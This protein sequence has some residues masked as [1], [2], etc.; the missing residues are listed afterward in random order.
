MMERSWAALLALGLVAGCGQGVSLRV[1]GP[2]GATPVVYLGQTYAVRS[3]ED[4]PQPDLDPAGLIRLPDGGLAVPPDTPLSGEGPALR[5]A[6]AAERQT[7]SDVA[8]LY[9]QG[10]GMDLQ[11]G[12]RGAPVRFDP[13]TAEHVF[14][15]DC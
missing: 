12:W 5:V 8:A 3:V 10:W 9:C 15:F 14:Y 11:P 6:G 7:A 2:D 13:A 1:P 4:E